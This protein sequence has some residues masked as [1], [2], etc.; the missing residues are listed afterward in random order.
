MP[1]EEAAK[2]RGK[3][4][5]V[6]PLYRSRNLMMRPYSS[7]KPRALSSPMVCHRQCDS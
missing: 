6:S 7:D 1:E 4:E 3:A 2:E 5:Y